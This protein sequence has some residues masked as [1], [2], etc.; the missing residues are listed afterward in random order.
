MQLAVHVASLPKNPIGETPLL[1]VRG[2]RPS[3]ALPPL[4]GSGGAR[5]RSVLCHLSPAE[6]RVP[7]RRRRRGRR[8]QGLDMLKAKDCGVTG[9]QKVPKRHKRVNAMFTPQ[10]K[11]LR[12]HGHDPAFLSE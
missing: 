12:H 7:R 8:R 2:H 6:R 5:R 11:H 3:R 1:A 10:A 4:R 9:G